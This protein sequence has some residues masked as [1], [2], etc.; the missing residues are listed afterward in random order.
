[1]TAVRFLCCLSLRSFLRC[2]AHT[3]SGN[4]SASCLQGHPPES[5][6]EPQSAQSQLRY[7]P[8]S[9]FTHSVFSVASVVGPISVLGAS[10]AV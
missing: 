3:K 9:G 7:G 10:L 8:E 5:D 6:I 2:A 4:L 1:M